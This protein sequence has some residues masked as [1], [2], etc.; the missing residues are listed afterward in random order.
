MPK[1]L[2][3]GSEETF[4]FTQEVTFEI[5]MSSG[6]IGDRKRNLSGR[7]EVGQEIALRGELM[8]RPKDTDGK[9]LLSI[10]TFHAL[11]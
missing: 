9:A 1:G 8:V 4:C 5:D 11:I 2:F 7:E 10:A 6:R 3:R